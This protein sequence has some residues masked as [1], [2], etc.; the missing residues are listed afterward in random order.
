MNHTE[1]YIYIYIYIER[2]RERESRSVDTRCKLTD[3]HQ[4]LT[5]KSNR[6]NGL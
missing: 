6:S 4:I 2:E 1:E 5:V 3:L